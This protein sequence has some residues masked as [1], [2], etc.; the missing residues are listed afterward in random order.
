MKMFK[1]LVLVVFMSTVTVYLMMTDLVGSEHLVPGFVHGCWTVLSVSAGLL[2]ASYL[3]HL[4]LHPLKS[5]VRGHEGACVAVWI[6]GNQVARR[7]N[8]ATTGFFKKSIS[9][10]GLPFGLT[11]GPEFHGYVTSKGIVRTTEGIYNNRFPD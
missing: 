6:E 10:A 8:G 3:I 11:V 5:E 2:A 1:F 9:I 4:R 7:I